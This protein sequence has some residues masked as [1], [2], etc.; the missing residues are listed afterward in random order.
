MSSQ[1]YPEGFKIEAIKQ[2]VDCGYSVSC[3]EARFDIT[4]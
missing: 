4:A 3:V 2:V 1:R